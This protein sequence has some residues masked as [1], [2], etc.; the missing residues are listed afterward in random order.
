MKSRNEEEIQLSESYS[1][2]V[3][4]AVAGGFLDA[5]TFLCRGGVFANAQTGNIVLLG[6]ALSRG[7][8]HGVRAAIAPIIA[9]VIGVFIAET[10]K[11]IFKTD[12]E[13]ALHWRHGILLIEIAILIIAGVIPLGHVDYLV[14]VLVSFV[15]SLQVQTFRTVHGNNFASTM[16]TGNLRSGTDAIFRFIRGKRGEDIEKAL[17]YY[18]II[19]FFVFGAVIG[20][21]VSRKAPSIGIFIPVLIYCIAFVVMIR[22]DK[23]ID[24]G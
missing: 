22:W 4:L 19:A 7:D 24:R 14:N 15:C 16:C 3:I 20:A 23:I 13:K 11:A 21:I 8:W 6:I 17:C 1:V 9:F 18:G 10:I 2:A 5:Y 12:E